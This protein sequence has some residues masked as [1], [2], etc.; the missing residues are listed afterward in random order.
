MGERLKDDFTTYLY[1][2]QRAGAR[3]RV[4]FVAAHVDLD[5]AWEYVVTYGNDEGTSK[6]I[7]SDVRYGETQLSTPG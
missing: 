2:E 6:G 5:R 4:D 7:P 3:S 1:H